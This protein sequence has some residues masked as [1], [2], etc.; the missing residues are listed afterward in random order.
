MLNEQRWWT[1]ADEA[2]LDLL[3]HEFV[4]AVYEHREGCSIC[5]AGGPW[6]PP[7]AH[8][9]QGVLDWREGRVLHSKAA[10]LREL[11]DMLDDERTAA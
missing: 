3:V 10:Y 9:F 4:K 5:R 2:E 1:S 11:Q 7:L 8:A 6:C